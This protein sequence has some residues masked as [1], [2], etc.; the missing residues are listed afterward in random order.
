[1]R[2]IVEAIR[3]GRP[4][5]GVCQVIADL[6]AVL[7]REFPRREDDRDE[8]SNRVIEEPKGGQR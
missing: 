5:D 8:L 3:A 7:E 1:M 6:G 4:A 2:H